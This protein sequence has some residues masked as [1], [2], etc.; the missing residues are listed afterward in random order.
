[1]RFTLFTLTAFATL[2]FAKEVF[3][4][5]RYER[6]SGRT[7]LEIQGADKAVLAESCSS[8]IGSL[9]FSNLDQIGR[10]FFT[11]G[12]KSFEVLS[13]A[14]E[15]TVCNTIYDDAIAIFECTGV[16]YDVPEVAATSAEDCF[17]HE[18]NKA[19]FRTLKSRSESLH[20]AGAPVE[21]IAMP[22]FHS[23]ILGSR[24]SCVFSKYKT[25]LV[26]DGNPHQNYLHKQ[27]SVSAE[28]LRALSI[29]ITNR[30]T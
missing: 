19:A 21:K 11:V 7:A 29:V 23:R 17:S 12:D 3:V 2:V 10:G 9:D 15:G 4:T 24:Q 8:K 16:E 25:K 26:G 6:S 18:D 27:L 1:M 30:H 13:N 28:F 22:S 14:K 20:L 5:Y